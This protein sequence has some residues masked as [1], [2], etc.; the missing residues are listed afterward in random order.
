ML[1]PVHA[2]QKWAV[3]QAQPGPNI[4]VNWAQA[5]T[6]NTKISGACQ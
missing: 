2:L 6:S 4:L 5:D 3:L 1:H